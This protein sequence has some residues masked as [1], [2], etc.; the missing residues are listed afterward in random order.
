MADAERRTEA[1]AETG[2]ALAQTAV[3]G[4][5]EL[6]DMTKTELL[7]LAAGMGLDVNSHQLKKELVTTIKRSREIGDRRSRGRDM[8]GTK[9]I[10]RSLVFG[11]G[12][13]A[14]TR[15][16]R[17]RYEQLQQVGR[18]LAVQLREQIQSAPDTARVHRRRGS[19]S[20]G[21]QRHQ[22]RKTLRMSCASASTS[23]PVC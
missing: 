16:G 12:Y 9:M 10:G 17:E 2:R 22:A 3:N 20:M 1:A 4:S 6:D 23:S 15:A 18:Q 14:G 13:L 5:G 8:L 21:R 11:L 19:E 7:E